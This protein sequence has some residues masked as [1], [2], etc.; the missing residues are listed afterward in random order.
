MKTR[1]VAAYINV[2]CSAIHKAELK[3]HVTDPLL[4]LMIQNVKA[5][6][7]MWLLT[8]EVVCLWVNQQQ[9]G[10]VVFESVKSEI[11]KRNAEM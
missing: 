10:H 4:V 11:D 6:L 9:L 7:S 5:T 3:K 1:L 8:N 2:L